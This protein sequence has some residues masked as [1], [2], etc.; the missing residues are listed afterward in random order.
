MKKFWIIVLSIVLSIVLIFTCAFAYSSWQDVKKMRHCSFDLDGDEEVFFYLE[1][2][3]SYKAIPFPKELERNDIINIITSM[4]REH[5]NTVNKADYHVYYDP[6]N[7]GIEYAVFVPLPSFL[8][9]LPAPFSSTDAVPFAY[10]A[11]QLEPSE[12]T[13]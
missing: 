8:E 4:K 11:V 1:D 3:R 13:Q 10:Y 9:L 6:F 12:N 2:G 5:L 7:E